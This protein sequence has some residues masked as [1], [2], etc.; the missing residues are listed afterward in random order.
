VRSLNTIGSPCNHGTSSHIR[1]GSGCLL[2]FSFSRVLTNLVIAWR[3]KHGEISRKKAH[4]PG[5]DIQY[6]HRKAL[7]WS[8]HMSQRPFAQRHSGFCAYYKLISFLSSL[9]APS[10][11]TLM[12]NRP[13]LVDGMKYESSN[14]PVCL[15]KPPLMILL[16]VKQDLIIIMS[17][18]NS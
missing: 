16:L 18:V 10:I 13:E 1:R 9:L 17:C 3:D 12:L 15:V 6:G 5:S 14:R 4:K 7:C 2:Y 11:I 8:I